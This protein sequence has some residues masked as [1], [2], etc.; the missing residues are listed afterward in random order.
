MQASTYMQGALRTEAPCSLEV[1]NRLSRQ[2]RLMHGMMGLV[3]ESGELMDAMKC[4]VFYGK[5]LDEVNIIE[6]VGDAAW[7]LAII[8]SCCQT[9][10][11][12]CFQI[13]HDK[14]E[15]RFPE[16]FEELKA[17]ERNLIEER[18][19]LEGAPVGKHEEESE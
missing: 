11:E 9:S 19:I 7:Y 15:A 16:K 1:I 13:N 18:R 12:D 5:S 8:L 3:T 6:E 2:A 17:L 10:F 4:H 14:L